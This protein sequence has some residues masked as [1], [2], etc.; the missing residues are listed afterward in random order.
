MGNEIREEISSMLNNNKY[1]L[2][3]DECRDIS[4]TQQ[5]SIVIRFVPNSN[6]CTTDKNYVVKEYFLGFIPLEKFDATTLA[7]NIV[8]FLN[9]WKIPL[10]S[11]ICLFMSGCAAGV[12]VLLKKYMPKGIYIHC[13]AHRLNLVI[14]D[15]CKVVY[16]SE[17]SSLDYVRGECL[18]TSVIQ[19]LKDLRNDQSFNQIYEK[20]KEFCSSN[21]IDFVQQYRSYRVTAVPIRF[22]EFIID[23][24]IGQRETLQTSTDY[25]NRLYFPLIDCMLVEL[26]DRFSLKTLSLMKSIS[27]VYPNSTNFL[28]IDAIDEFCFHIG[29]DSRALKNEFL[30]IKP[31][32]ESKKVN[33]VIELYNELVSMSDA[34]PQ[35][36]KMI[37]NTIT[38]PI[39]QVT[40]ERSFSK[41]KII[42]NYLRNSMTNERLSDLTVMAIEQDFEINY[43]RVIDKFSSNHKNCRILLL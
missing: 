38:M 23:S 18:I 19:Q 17:G 10:E 36:L 40:C 29:G 8:E 14:N 37:T 9:H 43:E 16:F 5:L 33:N 27:T 41:M 20:A 26:N 6:N 4:G 22:Q 3:A 13:A 30:V 31:M 15:T 12:H 35:T 32:L 2:M 1:A 7:N 21:E 25:L 34:F 42:K 39:S 11:C 28:N 24:T